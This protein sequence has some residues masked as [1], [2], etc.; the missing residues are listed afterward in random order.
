M[1]KKIFV[2]LLTCGYISSCLAQTD[3]SLN[4]LAQ[5]SHLRISL[6][7]CGVGEEA[8]ETFGHTGVRV[9]DSTKSGPERDVVFNYGMF[10]GFDKD[11]EI[12][13]MRG[14]LLYYVGIES[15]SDFVEEYLAYN[16]VVYE[17]EI[18]MNDSQKMELNAA[19]E[20]NT[21]PENRFY[22]YDFFF[23]NCATR[24][25]DIIPNTIKEGFVYGEAIPKNN[26]LSFRDII[27]QYLV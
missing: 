15:F 22:K 11:F 2:L 19:L 27:N 25:R 1:L 9:I 13:F 14:K 23:D 7:T 18:I 24:I 16:R 26:P 20:D 21:L 5:K 8:W 10:N 3:T 12:N 4:P 17:Q 6:L